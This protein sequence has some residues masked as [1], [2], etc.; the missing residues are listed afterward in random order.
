M[1]FAITDSPFKK[2]LQQQ[3]DAYFANGRSR[4]ATRALWIKAAFWL[5]SV[6]ALWG[7]LVFAPI[8]AWLGAILA[9]LAGF[10][11]A[12]V[13]FNVG[14]DAIHGSLSSNPN[15]NAIF[16]R[17][18]DVMGASSRMWGWAHNVVHHT[19]TNVPGTDHDLEPGFYLRFYPKNSRGFLH[20]FQHLYAF[21]LYFF[22]M[23]VWVFKKD[24]AQLIERGPATTRRDVIDVI[25][26]KLLHWAFWI[27]V[28][29]L[30]SPFAWWQVLIGYVLVLAMAGFTAAVVFQMAHVVEGPDFPKAKTKVSADGREPGE[31]VLDGDFY[32]HQLATTANFAPGSA[33]ATFFTGGLN[34]QVEHHLFPRIAHIHYPAL[35]P[36]VEA[37]AKKH[38][39]PYLAHKSFVAAL[40][41]HVR[42]LKRFGAGDEL[43]LG[44]PPFRTAEAR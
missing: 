24:F 21:G 23:L 11:I 29:M 39:V 2:D 18:F 26:G 17:S 19:Y 6:F 42:V 10:S 32:A 5:S 31:S 27:G 41:S 3:V 13:G 12:Q 33:V 14:H 28:P 7:V 30:L 44:P 1:K 16:A 4:N 38:G 15:V 37:C 8:P 22:T 43:E 40:A 25:A 20:R 36:I 34:H 9:L 35:A